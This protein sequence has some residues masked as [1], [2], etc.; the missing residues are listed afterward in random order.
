VWSTDK[1]G[2]IMGL[3]A[4]EMT[5]V[6]GCD[7]GALY[8]RLTHDFGA[9]VYQ[10]IDAPATPAQKYVLEQL[11]PQLRRAFRARTTCAA[12]LLTRKP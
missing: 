12:S 1:D 8:Q 7:P 3:P 4:A 2:I 11:S 5:A 10:R 9:P 6:M